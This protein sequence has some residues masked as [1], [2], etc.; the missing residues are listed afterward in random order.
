[1]LAH[2]PRISVFLCTSTAPPR[3]PLHEQRCQRFAK[4]DLSHWVSDRRSLM[5]NQTKVQ[6]YRIQPQALWRLACDH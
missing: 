2:S 6:P 5:A 1:L 4:E 3:V